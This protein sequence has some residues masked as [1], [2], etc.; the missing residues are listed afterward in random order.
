VRT[1]PATLLLLLLLVLGSAAC[2]DTVEGIQEDA[3]TIG[4][5]VEEGIEDATDE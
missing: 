2:D 1:T 4:E 5:E 3:D